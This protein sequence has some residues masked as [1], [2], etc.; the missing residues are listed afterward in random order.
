MAGATVT[1]AGNLT[2]APEL[3]Y[4]QNGTPV[5]SFTVAHTRRRLNRETNTWEDAGE[6]LFLRCSAWMQL[7]ENAAASLSKGDAVVVEGQ[8][9]QR[10][11]ETGE[12]EKRTVIE[13]RVDVVAVDLRR[14]TVATVM[15]IVKGGG[16]PEPSDSWDPAASAEA[17]TSRRSAAA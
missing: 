8:L 15:R 1:I 9:E 16:M 10:S 12:G 6:T 17:P 3:R 5:A 7:G 4:T 14:Q 13:C 2:S 11:Y